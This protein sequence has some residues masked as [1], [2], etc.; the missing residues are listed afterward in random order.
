MNFA[1]ST[2]Y[3][4]NFILFYIIFLSFFLL[5]SPTL[6]GLGAGKW[7]RHCIEQRDAAI[8]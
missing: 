6:C 5:I 4:E 2:Q 3:T 7:V 8:A 1:L